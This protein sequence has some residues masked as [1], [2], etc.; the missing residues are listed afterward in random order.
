MKHSFIT[1]LTIIAM[2]ACTSNNDNPFLCEWNTPYGIPPF[3]QIHESDYMPAI[4]AGITQQQGEIE[5][6]INNPDEP[7]F[8][9]TIAALDRSGS[10]L[11]KVEGVLFNLCETDATDKLNAVVEEAT[12]VITDWDN[13]IFMN[14]DL[15]RR[16]KVIYDNQDAL[17]LDSEQKMLL[18]SYYRSF[19]QNGIDL[20][21]DKRER[22]K[23]INSE[24]SMLQLRFGNNLLAES[25]AFA[26]KFGISVSDYP[27]TMAA[28]SDRQ[29]REAMFRAYSE[30]G[31]NNN[32]ND[33]KQTVLDIIRLR[34]EKAQLLGY[35]TPAVLSVEDKMAKTP[36]A[37]DPFLQSIIT[38]AIRKAK[39][40]I[41][42]MQEIM[43]QD[44]KAGLLPAGSKIEAWDWAYYAERVRKA[45]YAL[46]EEMT[47]PYF[48]MENVRAGVFATAARLYDL[49]FEQLSDIPLYNPEVEGFKVTRKDGSLVGILLTDYFPRSTKRG[50]A[51]MNNVRNQWV[52][53]A[54]E[55]IRPIIVNVGNLAK[56]TADNPS[57]LSI[58]NV[59]TMFHEF[60]HALHGLLSECKYNGT[61]GTAVPT[62]FVEMLSQ[63]NEN[64]AFQPEVLAT[65]ATH[66]QSGEVIPAELVEKINKAG[67]FNQGFMTTELAAASILD[68]KWHEITSIYVPEDC[69]WASETPAPD[70]AELRVIDPVKFEKH[71][72]EEMGLI[73]EIIPR[74]R[75][76]YF[77]HIFNS[78][79]SAGYY[80]YLWAEVLDKDGFELFRQNG[81]FDKATANSLK[82][83]ILSKG[84]SDEA[85]EL[86]R[87]FRGADPD[88]NALL[89]ARGLE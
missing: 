31:N 59:G 89:K 32:E 9:N 68:M 49:E 29:L 33:N 11:A 23:E 34:I 37:V 41:K 62:D 52:T 69:E 24:I 21:A 45:K 75:T 79:Y 54:G 57:L 17:N 51:W 7:T 71:I 63:I 84:G 27:E 4:K 30:R 8:D 65:Y 77:N 50:G 22:L 60:G 82:E 72:C 14:E 1:A 42:D 2:T 70:N 64:W 18:K 43:D 86:F 46:D 28:T 56:P 80:S 40:E 48:Q 6:I 55:D 85:M 25:N 67:T 73:D 58:D 87:R 78:G 26:E 76:T 53:V 5:L 15:F 74:Y 39:E 35:E 10:I 81:V 3:E 44:I 16:V 88:F 61:S 19:A 12:P 66:Y 38:P 13:S 20:P 83:N 36:E 47:R